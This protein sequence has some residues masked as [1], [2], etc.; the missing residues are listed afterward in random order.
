MCPAHT[1]VERSGGS[2][3][4]QLRFKQ[5]R[6]AEEVVEEQVIFVLMVVD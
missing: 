2:T 4:R 6:L 1:V 3:E 5:P